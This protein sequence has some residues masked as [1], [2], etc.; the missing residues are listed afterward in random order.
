MRRYWLI[1]GLGAL[2][3]TKGEGLLL[4]QTR[5]EELYDD[6]MVLRVME[7]IQAHYVDPK[8]TDYRNLTYGALEGLLDS[9]DPH[10]Q[11]LTPDHYRALQ[12][13]TEGQF[14]G[15][16]LT[17]GLKEGTVTIVA[18]AD[19]SPGAK[20]GLVSG[21]KILRV[22]DKSTESMNLMDVANRLRG[23][24]GTPVKLTIL[25]DKTEQIE[26]FT[27]QRAVVKSQ[28][29]REVNLLSPDLTDRYAI[30]YI[31]LT[32]FNDLTGRDFEKALKT[33]ELRKMQGL[34]LD[35]RNNPGGLLE[36]AVEVAGKF[37]DPN[38]V[39]VITQGRS[40]QNQ[41][42]LRSTEGEKHA[43]YPIV[44]L[45]NTGSASGAEIVAGALKD[46]KK[47]VLI[48]E[49]SFGKGSVQS[50]FPLP[51]GSALRLTTAYYY[52]PQHQLIHER[53]ITPDITVVEDSEIL[54]RAINLLKGILIYSDY[55]TNSV[56]SASHFNP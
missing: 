27:L 50:L 54:P 33:L 36:A 18:P 42:I 37:I 53:G 43:G 28:S 2:F 5:Q 13:Q 34:I 51:D 8:K 22:D 24:E 4:A 19:D 3:F 14:V 47:A 1:C 11:F 46:W 17:L 20:A 26:E 35:L 12:N 56:V 25:R 30:G 38:E 29:I 10:S 45:I 6:S 16:G 52:T 55:L 9:L 40:D 48:G 7:M 49:T 39:I 41:A 21:D 44:I 15:I 31:R 32:Q 23:K